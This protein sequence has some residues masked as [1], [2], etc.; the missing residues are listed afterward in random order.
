[1]YPSGLC[2]CGQC[3]TWKIPWS[4]WEQ[5]FPAVANWL[6][7]LRLDVWIGISGGSDGK[8]STC[9]VGDLGSIPGLGRCPGEGNSYPF[10]YSGLENSMDRGGWQATVHAVSKSWT[11][12]SDFHFQR[13]HVCLGW[14]L[15]SKA[16]QFL[17]TCD[18]EILWCSAAGKTLSRGIL[19]DTLWLSWEHFRQKRWSVP[20]V[21]RKLSS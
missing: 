9:N 8:E 3:V 15:V 10:Q 6:P 5:K 7:K 17:S 12:L 2:P 4:R 13:Y 21:R 11:Q 18:A 16:V 19:R 1:M 20:R 14:S